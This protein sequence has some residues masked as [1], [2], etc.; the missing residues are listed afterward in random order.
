MTSGIP[1]LFPMEAIMGMRMRLA[2]V[3]EMKVATPQAKKRM[4]TKES[5][6]ELVGN[7]SVTASER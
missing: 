3:C 4:T 5:Q 2:T 7:T 6:G 1:T